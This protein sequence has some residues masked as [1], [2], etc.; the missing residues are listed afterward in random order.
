MEGKHGGH[1]QRNRGEMRGRMD[2]EGQD[3]EG[4]LETGGGRGR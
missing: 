3:Y 2:D 4:K 1:A